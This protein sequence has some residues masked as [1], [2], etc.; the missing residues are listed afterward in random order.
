MKS[1]LVKMDAHA[2]TSE[3]YDEIPE[4]TDAM[5]E[6]ADFYSGDR[7]VRRGPPDMAPGMADGPDTI[8]L[9]PDVAAHFRAQGPGWQA[10]VNALLLEAVERERGETPR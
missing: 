5:L 9:L 4:L 8:R 6:R 10:R 1:D 7:F 3:E 2:I